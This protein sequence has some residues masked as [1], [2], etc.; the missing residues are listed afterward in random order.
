MALVAAGFGLRLEKESQ[1]DVLLC[2]E[3]LSSFSKELLGVG[4]TE[5]ES[6]EEEQEADWKA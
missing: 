2:F 4:G 1:S 5:L 3:R 6:L